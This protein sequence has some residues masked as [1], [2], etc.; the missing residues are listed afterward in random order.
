[1]QDIKKKK[2][3]VRDDDEEDLDEEDEVDDEE[4]LDEEDEP[5]TPVIKKAGDKEKNT[6]TT[7]SRFIVA[8]VPTAY[9]PAVIDE[10]LKE[11]YTVVEILASIKNDLE[12]I[13]KR[14]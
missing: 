13:K 5:N 8:N 4:D 14:L 1:M 11:R 3:R 6:E 9:E 2:K 10:E 7:K 12:E